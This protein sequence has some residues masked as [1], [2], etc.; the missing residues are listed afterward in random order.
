MGEV[1]GDD[2]PFA[3]LSEDLSLEPVEWSLQAGN[4]LLQAYHLPGQP[5][6]LGGEIDDLL[7]A[8]PGRFG[9][10]QKRCFGPREH[11]AIVPQAAVLA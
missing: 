9:N 11:A 8:Q 7:R 2:S 3:L 1:D 5:G 10:A 6:P 4:L